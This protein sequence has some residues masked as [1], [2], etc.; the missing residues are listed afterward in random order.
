MP[1][2][3]KEHKT[4]LLIHCD[5][6][7]KNEL[8][9]SAVIENIKKI[10]NIKFLVIPEK[11]LKAYNA[12]FRYPNFSF[13]KKLIAGNAN[14]K[15][16]FLGGLQTQA[17]EI[18]LKN[19]CYISF[20]MPDFILSDDFLTKTFLNIQGKKTVLATGF[21]TDYQKVMAS[22]DRFFSD[23]EKTKLSLPAKTLTEFKAKYIHAAARRRVVA[24]STINYDPCAQLLFETPNGF[25]VRT[26]HLHPVLL[27]CKHYNHQ[28]TKDYYPIDNTVLDQILT[29][30][31]PY[32]QQAYICDN[33]SE[34]AFME[35]S[36]TTMYAAPTNKSIKL[37]YQ[38]LVNRISMMISSAPGIY[39][40]PLNRYF[41]SVKIKF[42]SPEI[43][44]TGDFIVDDTF[45]SDLEKC[46]NK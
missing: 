42:E 23:K 7:T 18:A 41:H 38:E 16:V 21:R 40:S 15:Y 24:S 10:A 44:K 17:L 39:S 45:F 4:T 43:C 22:L 26:F 13:F 6:E 30:D 35:L 1:A 29:R 27:D 28:I 20:L 36:D 11:L 32:Q 3:T 12:S 8:V 34:I 14:L 19:K 31:A 25:I 9:A 5:V 33:A 46:L 37:N 2:T